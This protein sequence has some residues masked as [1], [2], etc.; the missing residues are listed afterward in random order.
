MEVLVIGG[1]GREHALVWKIARSPL[2]NRISVTDDNPGFPSHVEK[3]QGDVVEFADRAGVDLVVVGPEAPLAAG[4]VDA[5]EER[6]IAAFG[7][8]RAAARLETSKAF[9]KGFME[10]HRIPTAR[11]S[12]HERRETAHD[13]V[14]GPCVVKADGLAAGKGVYVCGE[15]DEAHAAIDALFDGAVGG[16]GARVLVEERLTGPELSLLALCDG[17]K[18]VALLPCRDYKRRFDG[19]KG[20]NTGGMGA[21]CP[22]PG[23]DAGLLAE[24]QRTVLDPTVRGMAAEGA[25]FRGVLYAGLM[26]TPAGPR[27]LEYNVRFGDPEC[28]PLM[29]MLDQDV[30][31]LLLAAARGAL[32]DDPIRWREGGAACVVMVD[33]G[34]PGDLKRGQPITGLPVSDPDVTVFFAGAKR[35]GDGIVTSGGRVLGVTGWGS[36]LT[37]GRARAGRSGGRARAV[38][39]ALLPAR[40]GAPAARSTQGRRPARAAW[41]ARRDHRGDG[42]DGGARRAGVAAGPTGGGRGGARGERAASGAAVSGGGPAGAGRGAGV[43]RDHRGPARRVDRSGGVERGGARLVRP[44]RRHA[45]A[46]EG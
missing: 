26:L 14:A 31:P 1:G 46:E 29:V 12:V 43:G 34:Y 7:P 41:V 21:V 38:Q 6:G 33:G 11:W 4:I 10:R 9:A 5:L 28:Q 3:V 2:V 15:D 42:A 17:R 39:P 19:D 32:P 45:P 20:P 30:V 37:A 40:R 24:L 16:A 18:A 8:T 36:R 13:A 22:A 44:P 27:V 25:P 23:V 35:V